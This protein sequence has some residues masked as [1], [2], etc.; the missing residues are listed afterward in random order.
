[1]TEEY[2]YLAYDIFLGYSNVVVSDTSDIFSQDCAY[3]IACLTFIEKD[4]SLFINM[5]C[6]SE[7]RTVLYNH[8]QFSVHLTGF[9]VRTQSRS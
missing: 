9:S 2:T 1:M 6:F 3:S 7:L 4:R 8:E 5:S